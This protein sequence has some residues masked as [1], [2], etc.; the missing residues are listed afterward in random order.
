MAFNYSDNRWKWPRH[1]FH[2]HYKTPSDIYKRDKLR[3]CSITSCNWFL[4]CSLFLSRRAAS[5]IS[6]EKALSCDI[7]Q[8]IVSWQF[9]F[10]SIANLC[11]TAADRYIAIVIPFIRTLRSWPFGPTIFSVPSSKLMNAPH[12]RVP[13]LEYP[14]L[15]YSKSSMTC[16]LIYYLAYSWCATRPIWLISMRN[17]ND[18]NR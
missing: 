11:V 6:F 3:V 15:I 1:L 17:D 4:L 12:R 7:L 10:V 9:A 18:G 13:D 5:Y 2:R 14:T 16:C 8:E